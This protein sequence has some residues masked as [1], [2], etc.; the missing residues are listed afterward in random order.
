MTKAEFVLVRHSEHKSVVRFK[1]QDEKAPIRDV[2]VSRDL[3]GINHVQHVKITIEC[4]ST[5]DIATELE[6]KGF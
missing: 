5:L 2:Y 4:K 1:A 3:D 6:H